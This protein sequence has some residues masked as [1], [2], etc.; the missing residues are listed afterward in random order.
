MVDRQSLSKA[1]RIKEGRIIKGDDYV[2][3]IRG[4]AGFTVGCPEVIHAWIVYT[5]VVPGCRLFSNAGLDNW[6][7][8][9]SFISKKAVELE[10]R[11]P[12]CRR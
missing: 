7:P 4:Y 3:A 5:N 6:S 10:G 11:A 9:S 12:A 8:D 1:C 2:L